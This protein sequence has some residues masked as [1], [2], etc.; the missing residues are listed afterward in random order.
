MDPIQKQTRTGPAKATRKIRK[1]PVNPQMP[2]VSVLIPAFNAEEWVGDTIRSALSQSWPNKEVIVVD[3]GSKDQTLAV[4]RRFESQGVRVVRQENKGASAARNNAFS[5]SKGDYIQWLDADDLLAPDKIAKQMSLVQQG[6]GPRTLLSAAWGRFMYRPVHAEFKPTPLWCDLTPREW[7]LR[8]MEGNV[9]MQTS[10]WL[11]SREVTEAA[12]PWDVRML[13]DDDGE[14]F[15][16]VLLASDAVRFVP[17]AKV[18]YRAFRFDS[19][20]YI[21]RFPHKIEAHW[22]SMKLHIKY[23]RSLGDDSRA[24]AACLQFIRD[25]MIYFY[26]ESPRVVEEARSLG[27]ELGGDLGD[28][29]LTWRYAWIRVLFGWNATK[30]AQRLIRRIRWGIVRKIDYLL[31]CRENKRQDVSPTLMAER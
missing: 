21:G 17:D 20:S 22:A 31:F 4:A 14:Y 2:L 1:S 15:C 6:L 18:Y 5:L 11:V 27:R 3:D 8:K 9:F 28:P 24:R 10:V 23:V 25:S 19:L 26:P 30:F 12:G 16:R 13:G 7:L 29:P